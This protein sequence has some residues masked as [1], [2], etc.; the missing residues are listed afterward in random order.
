MDKIE[1]KFHVGD[2]VTNISEL[3]PNVTPT[4]NEV[5]I[6]NQCY[7]YKEIGGVTWFK[8]Q[9]K[10]KLVDTKPIFKVGDKVKG[11]SSEEPE[12]E[13]IINSINEDIKCYH[14]FNGNG[15]ITMFKDQHKLT[16]V[17]TDN[18]RHPVEDNTDA[19]IIG[20]NNVKDVNL[21]LKVEEVK[22]IQAKAVGTKIG[23]SIIETII[24]D[25]KKAAAE[26]KSEIKIKYKDYNISNNNIP[27]VCYWGR[28]CGFVV[29][30]YDELAYIKW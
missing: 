22:T 17:Q 24:R 16:L 20:N 25:I 15:I 8:E 28:I 1:P 30:T 7:R 14:Y 2:V 23:S 27:Y 29:S 11:A 4:I 10:L 9:D 18:C 19:A 26:G 12:K 13:F 6:L 5:D 21:Y 3:Y